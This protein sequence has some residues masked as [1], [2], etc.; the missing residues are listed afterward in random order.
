MIKT[1]NVNGGIICQTLSSWNCGVTPTCRCNIYH[2]KL[3]LVC[4]VSLPS[5]KLSF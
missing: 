4:K 3:L 2:L 5:M 1:I